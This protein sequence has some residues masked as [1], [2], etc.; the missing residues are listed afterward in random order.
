MKVSSS[1]P[2]ATDEADLGEEDERQDGR[3]RAN[4][5][6]STMPARGDHAAG[7]REA[8]QHPV[9]RAVLAASP[10]ARAPSGRCCSRCPAPP[11]RRT[12]TAGATGRAREAEDDVEDDRRRR[13]ARRR[14]DRT[15]VPISSSETR[16]GAQQR[17]SG[18]GTRRSARAAR[19]G[20]C[21][22]AA[23]SRRSFS[24]AVAPPTTVPGPPAC[25]AA[26]SG[27][28]SIRS[29]ASIVYGSGFRTASRI[30][31]SGPRLDRG[32]GDRRRRRR[33]RRLTAAI[34]AAALRRVAHDDVGR[35]AGA[36]GEGLARAAPAPSGDSTSLAERV[37]VGQIG[38]DVEQAERRSTSSTAAARPRRAA[39][40]GRHASPRRRQRRA[41]R[42][43]PC[44]RSAG[45]ERPERACGR[46]S[47][48]ARA[49][50]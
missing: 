1:T 9:A 8:A 16:H 49:A 13:R 20:A 43:C 37:A 38:R 21:R 4:V 41:S 48:A 47:R 27:S 19:S 35:R 44:R 30:A 40:C 3:A 33:R 23:A 50:A 5:P 26:R 25:L 14:S 11:G 42:R 17:R 12:R 10:R 36:A 31:P 6:A 7:H 15:T 24:I 18:S 34:T 28:A 22:G 45:R 39:G 32:R 2:K 46:R 29:N